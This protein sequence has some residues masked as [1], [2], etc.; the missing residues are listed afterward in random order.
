MS[1]L[2]ILGY[3]DHDT[4][5]KAYEEVQRL[6]NDHIVDLSG[7]AVVTVDDKGR[8][9]VDTPGKVV[10]G[11]ATSGALWGTLIGLLFLAPIGGL[12]FGGAL[13]ALMGKLGK[14]GIDASFRERVQ[15]MLTPGRA[16]VVIMTTKITEDKFAS[17]LKPYG[18]E[19]LQTSLSEEDEKELAG[20]LSGS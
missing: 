5:V 13:G 17:A 10:S 19:V 6:Q 7:L 14:S 18:G 9:H 8:S 11:S 1:D 3:Q 16:A 15:G 2:I 20:E 4:A 12:I